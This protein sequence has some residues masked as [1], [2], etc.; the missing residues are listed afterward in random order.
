MEWGAAFPKRERESERD[1][2][3]VYILYI[4]ILCF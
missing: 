3:G 4:A 2:F 1:Y